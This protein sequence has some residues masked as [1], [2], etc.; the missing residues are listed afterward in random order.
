MKLLKLTLTPITSFRA[1]F[2][3]LNVFKSGRTFSDAKFTSLWKPK[4]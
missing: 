4:A 2:L 3:H 1:A